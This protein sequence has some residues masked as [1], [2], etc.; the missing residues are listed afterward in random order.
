LEGILPGLKYADDLSI[1]VLRRER[2]YALG[3]VNVFSASVGRVFSA[4]V[5]RVFDHA[6]VVWV[7]RFNSF[8][9]DTAKLQSHSTM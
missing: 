4:S 7:S 1:D 9:L 3:R 5:E 6:D 2:R 8:P